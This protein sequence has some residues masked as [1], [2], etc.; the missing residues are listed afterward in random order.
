MIVVTCDSGISTTLLCLKMSSLAKKVLYRA[1]FEM[2]LKMMLH[3]KVLNG[4]LKF[5]VSSSP[6]HFRIREVPA[7]Y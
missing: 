6:H 2:P 5:L 4:L 3:A 7:C 1:E